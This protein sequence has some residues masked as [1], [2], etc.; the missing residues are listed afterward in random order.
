MDSIKAA[1]TMA[2]IKLDLPHQSSSSS[3]SDTDSDKCTSEEN[4]KS[5]VS[6]PQEQN[7]AS[8]PAEVTKIILAMEKCKK[9]LPPEGKTITVKLIRKAKNDHQREEDWKYEENQK[10]YCY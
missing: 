5:V 8:M 4:D 2:N 9:S 3:S 7:E 10:S 6:S 1:L